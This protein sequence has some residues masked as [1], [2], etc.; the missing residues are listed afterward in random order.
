MKIDN[1]NTI[2]VVLNNHEA[3]MLNEVI[4]KGI[5]FYKSHLDVALVTFGEKVSDDILSHIKDD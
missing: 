4:R 3:W 2:S 1:Y 5:E